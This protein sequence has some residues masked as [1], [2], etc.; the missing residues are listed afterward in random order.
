MDMLKCALGFIDGHGSAT[1]HHSFGVH[2]NMHTSVVEEP[3]P[4]FYY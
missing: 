1:Q 4:N 3:S 2:R